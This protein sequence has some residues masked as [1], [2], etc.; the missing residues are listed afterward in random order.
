MGLVNLLFNEPIAYPF[1][2]GDTFV[3]L[4]IDEKRL[5][6]HEK[7]SFGCYGVLDDGSLLLI[8]EFFGGWHA[9]ED[10]LAQCRNPQDVSNDQWFRISREEFERLCDE[11]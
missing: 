11:V 7:D 3:F 9:E 1:E 6:V 10:W 4:S 2:G 8:C 5:Y